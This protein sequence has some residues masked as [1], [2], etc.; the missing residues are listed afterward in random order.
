MHNHG[1]SQAFYLKIKYDQ[2]KAHKRH[3]PCIAGLLCGR[4]LRCAG[5]DGDVLSEP[6]H[7]RHLPGAPPA[8]LI[9]E[10]HISKLLFLLHFSF[11]FHWIWMKL[12]SFYPRAGVKVTSSGSSYTGTW[13]VGSLWPSDS[14]EHHTAA[15]H[16]WSQGALHLQPS[17]FRRFSEVGAPVLQD[18]TAILRRPPG[19][20]RCETH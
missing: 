13:Q 1:P 2:D 12:C 19:R 8:L 11:T 14:E 20:Q 10:P 6:G 3:C 9:L 7:P 18:C 15:L 4:M 17:L 16:T 5:E